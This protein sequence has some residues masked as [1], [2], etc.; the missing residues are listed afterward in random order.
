[1]AGKSQ[2]QNQWD[3]S[4]GSKNRLEKIR[5]Y[6]SENLENDLSLAIVADKFELSV[7]SL[8]NMFKTYEG[9]S[10]HQYVTDIRM[11]KAFELIT[12]E[13][14]RIQQVMYATGYHY[15]STFNKAFIKKFKHRPGY[16][17]R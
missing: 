14:Q 17:Q 12:K 15:K 8:K 10:Y 16:F 2:I 7:S 1:M 4:S 9:K 11:E 6:L 13:G 3:E 5:Q